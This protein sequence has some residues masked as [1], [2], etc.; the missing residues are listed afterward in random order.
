MY[1]T[2][3][4][5]LKYSNHLNVLHSKKSSSAH[6]GNWFV[7]V[8]E[9]TVSKF[10]YLEFHIWKLLGNELNF[11]TVSNLCI[12]LMLTLAY[13]LHT[14]SILWKLFAHYLD[15]LCLP[16]NLFI[17]NHLYIHS[18]HKILFK[19]NEYNCTHTCYMLLKIESVGRL[20]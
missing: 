5:S 13:P 15:T 11:Q 19:H 8:R 12:L 20:F 2:S 6:I 9:Q 7:H 3:V 14:E 18:Y 16:C 17:A 1:I 10:V 4:I